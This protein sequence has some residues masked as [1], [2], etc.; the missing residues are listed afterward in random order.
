MEKNSHYKSDYKRSIYMI[1]ENINVDLE[2]KKRT[3]AAIEKQSDNAD[4]I[5]LENKLLDITKRILRE[6]TFIYLK[7]GDIVAFE[8]LGSTKQGVQ[9]KDVALLLSS[10]GP[11][12]KNLKLCSALEI[13]YE[14]NF[15]KGI[16]QEVTKA[17]L[18]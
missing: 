5:K 12:F 13:Y 15:I 9:S 10:L 17:D 18:I 3:E 1:I 11:Y 14:Y 8:K 16:Y 6:S 2:K 4:K 7:S